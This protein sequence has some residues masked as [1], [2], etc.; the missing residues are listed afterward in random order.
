ML[1]NS[2]SVALPSTSQPTFV[3]PP[4]LPDKREPPPESDARTKTT[5]QMYQLVANSVSVF[6]P[7]VP[8]PEAKVRFGRDDSWIDCHRCI[9]P[10]FMWV[11]RFLKLNHGLIQPKDVQRFNTL[12]GQ[13]IQ[14]RDN[15]PP[16]VLNPSLKAKVAR[17]V[18]GKNP[19]QTATIQIFTK[20]Q[21]FREDVETPLTTGAMNRLQAVVEHH[22]LIRTLLGPEHQSDVSYKVPVPA[23]I[24]PPSQA[25]E[26]STLP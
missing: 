13:F 9:T 5:G 22:A 4:R 26:T 23:D 25:K 8:V 21:K 16:D 1:T 11:S 19:G 12:W 24:T 7:D 18:L 2:S 17:Y 10:H 14:S 20:L 15:P 6:W 3:S